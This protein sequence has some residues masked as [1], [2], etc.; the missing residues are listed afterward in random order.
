MTMEMK[1]EIRYRYT[2]TEP[3]P[4]G[5]IE[6]YQLPT[7]ELVQFNQFE[8]KIDFSKLKPYIGRTFAYY[9]DGRHVYDVVLE[10]FTDVKG[11]P[12]IK[13]N[14]VGDGNEQ[15]ASGDE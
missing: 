12:A 3:K 15:S 6:S 13:I 4:V 7:G 10:G 2:E 14:K 5:F 9:V 8:G 1:P 11:V